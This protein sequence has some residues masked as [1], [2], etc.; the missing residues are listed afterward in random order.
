MEFAS[1][2]RFLKSESMYGPEAQTANSRKY[3]AVFGYQQMDETV[4][5]MD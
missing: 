5:Q 2:C 1:H 4:K 3:T